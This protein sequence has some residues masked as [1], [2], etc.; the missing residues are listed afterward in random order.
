MGF[1]IDPNYCAPIIDYVYREG[2][3]WKEAEKLF[4]TG[5][6]TILN[7]WRFYYDLPICTA[8]DRKEQ[9]EKLIEANGCTTTL[10]YLQMI[11]RK[12]E[13]RFKGLYELGQ[14]WR[15]HKKDDGKWYKTMMK[16]GVEIEEEMQ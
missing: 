6:T 1:C 5:A 9:L 15:V 8:P 14:A 7:G 16:D 11:Q 12:N 2:N 13:E 10:E 4:D 3:N